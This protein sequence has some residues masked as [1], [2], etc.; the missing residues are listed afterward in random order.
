MRNTHEMVFVLGYR[1]SNRHGEPQG[2][3]GFVISQARERLRDQPRVGS[4]GSEHLIKNDIGMDR[5]AAEKC[6]AI[7]PAISPVRPSAANLP[8]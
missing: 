3:W 1:N 7:S 6:V 2:N 5:V 4:V 8:V